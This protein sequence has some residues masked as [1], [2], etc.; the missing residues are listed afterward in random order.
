MSCM[1]N[2]NGICGY[3]LFMVFVNLFKIS[4][5]LFWGMLRL[6]FFFSNLVRVWGGDFCF[7]VDGRVLVF[8]VLF[9][10][11]DNFVVSDRLWVVGLGS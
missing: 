10:V 11:S 1:L 9:D 5:R 3:L 7:V 8:L 4:I 2:W 6:I